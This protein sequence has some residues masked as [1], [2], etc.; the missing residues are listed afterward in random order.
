MLFSL[1]TSLITLAIVLVFFVIYHRL[2]ANNRSLEKVKR[3]ADKLQNGLDD[4]VGARS[5]ELKHYGIDLDVQQKAAKIALE[6]LQAAQLAVTEKADA[7]GAI[8]DRFKEYDE[9]LAKLMDMTARV[10]ENLTRIHED[11]TFAEG[12]NRKLDLAK[13]GLAAIEREL[14]LLRESFAQE[15]QRTIETFRDDILN[16]LQE[17]LATTATELNNVRDEALAAFTQ[18]QSA[19]ALVDEELGKALETAQ[20]R[21][22]SVEDEAFA[23][24]TASF[25]SRLDELGSSSARQLAQLGQDTTRN[26]GELRSA[27]EAFKG[28]WHDEAQG[29]LID[30]TT[31]LGEAEDIFARKA[32]EIA[33]L[34]ESSAKMA[35]DKEREFSD[36]AARTENELT[37]IAGKA[38]L[39][40]GSTAAKARQDMGSTL[41]ELAALESSL[42]TAMEATKTHI[43]E[44]F[45]AFGQAFEDHRSRFEADFKAETSALGLSLLKLGKDIETLKTAAYENVG[46]KLEGF[47]DQLLSDLSERKSEAFKRLDAW[48]SDIEKTLSGTV[49]AVKEREKDKPSE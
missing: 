47:E 49:D 13:K 16:E 12:V 19:R 30:I 46:E 27:I 44:E 43:E 21:A 2:T 10:D 9:V 36:T 7:V 4:Y 40:L 26:I 45:A 22:S 24:L 37:E 34:L 18:A 39:E 23:T 33:G 28:K 5:E 38:K 31:K 11:E 3:L 25:T 8:A 14:P 1:G 41:A 17:G 29:M 48:L 35:S 42:K 32:T 6:K 15:A 20:A